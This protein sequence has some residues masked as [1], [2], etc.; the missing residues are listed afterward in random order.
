MSTVHVHAPRVDSLPVL[1]PSIQ[2]FSENPHGI[3]FTK[4]GVDSL[5]SVTS[6]VWEDGIIHPIDADYRNRILDA[7]NRLALQGLRVL[8]VA[9]RPALPTETQSNQL[10]ET[11]ER[12]LI[13]IG[14]VGMMDPPREEVAGAVQTCLQAGI[15]PIM[16]TGDQPLTALQIGRMLKIIP[17][18]ETRVLTGVEID[19]M[20]DDAL[21]KSTGEIS[22]YARVSPENKLRI[23]NALQQNGEV[24]AMTGDGVND[25]PALRKSDIG[26]AMGITGTDVSKEAASM[27]ILDDNFATIVHAV[28]EGR[29]VYDNVRKFIRYTLGSNAGEILV[30]FFAPLLGMPLPLTPLQILWMNLVTDGL[31]GLALTNEPADPEIMN[32]PPVKPG[33]SI[34]SRGVG[35]YIFR[36]GVVMAV[37]TLAFGWYTYNSGNPNWSTM[38]FTLLIFLQIGHALGIR[39]DS[40]SI[41]KQPVKSNPFVYYAAGI[42]V[43]LQMAAIY[44]PPMQKLFNTTPLTV[45]EFLVTLVASFGVMIWIEFEKI[46]KRR[47]LF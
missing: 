47:K 31:P 42:T 36:I 24:A 46:T 6:G 38:I 45:N 27:V 8:G 5:L 44:W 35:A 23:V 39:S 10:P 29:R 11:A 37:I 9:Y 2:V 21:R 4:G 30:M 34:F 14:L 25:A 13:L 12:D 41:F 32:H 3:I 16:I 7:N 22:I 1:S 26:V 40:E 20:D 17:E 19:R 28:E 18:Q 15:R 43:F 33:E